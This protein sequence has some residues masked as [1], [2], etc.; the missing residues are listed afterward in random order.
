MGSLPQNTFLQE[1]RN[2]CTSFIF[3]SSLSLREVRWA[4]ASEPKEKGQAAISPSVAVLDRS[5]RKKRICYSEMSF[6]GGSVWSV[7]C[8]NSVLQCSWYHN[9]WMWPWRERAWQ[10]S[11]FFLVFV[12]CHELTEKGNAVQEAIRNPVPQ[13]KGE[14]QCPLPI[15]LYKLCLWILSCLVWWSRLMVVGNR[16]EYKT[17]KR[18]CP[19]PML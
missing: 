10:M 16:A 2:S 12:I 7:H 3:M 9:L 1:Q 17:Q 15:A 19:F 4:M 8:M 6:L 11:V 18:D 14:A 13:R 5:I